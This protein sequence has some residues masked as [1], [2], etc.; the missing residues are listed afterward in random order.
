[1]NARY[2]VLVSAAVLGSVAWCVAR[3][4]TFRCGQ[5]IASPEMS[6]D[7]LVEKCGPPASKTTEIVEVYGPATSGLG[8]VK[9]GTSI[10][11]KW[12]YDRGSQSFDMVVTIVD[13][14]IRSMERA[15]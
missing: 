11:E 4:E 1:M 3:A 12:L 14:E 15:E 2:S 8:R 5:W 7:E 10:I 9:R 6:V 13:G